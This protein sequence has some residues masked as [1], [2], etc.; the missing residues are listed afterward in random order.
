MISAPG[1]QKPRD[2]RDIESGV[3]ARKRILVLGGGFGGLHTARQL[4]R[5]V[6]HEAAVR[7]ELV[8][9]IEHDPDKPRSVIS[10]VP[11]AL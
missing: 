9:R 3:T 4:E 5:I 7:V 6:R 10:R 2:R 11:P 1:A 8:E